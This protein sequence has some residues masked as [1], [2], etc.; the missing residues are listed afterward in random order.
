MQLVELPELTV[1]IIAATAEA[2]QME[3]PDLAQLVV[4]VVQA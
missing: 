3:H 1:L 4:T 2:V